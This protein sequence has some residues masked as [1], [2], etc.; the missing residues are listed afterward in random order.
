LH[1]GAHDEAAAV[2]LGGR[3]HAQ[4]AVGLPMLATK[5]C[6]QLLS[7]GDHVPI[8]DFDWLTCRE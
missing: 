1:K 7:C 3:V 2:V 6:L 4:Q 5:Q 8:P